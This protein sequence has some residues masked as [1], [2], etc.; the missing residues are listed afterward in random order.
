MFNDEVLTPYCWICTELHSISRT[1]VIS[2]VFMLCADDTS[3]AFH[4]WFFFECLYRNTQIIAKD[5]SWWH[6]AGKSFNLLFQVYGLILFLTG[7][8][9]KL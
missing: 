9:A 4:Q 5:K 1:Q 8:L 2:H 3:Y 7:S 6:F